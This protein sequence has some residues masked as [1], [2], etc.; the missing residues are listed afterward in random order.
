MKRFAMLS[1]GILISYGIYENLQ[2]FREPS[3]EVWAERSWFAIGGAMC[4][5]LIVWL[6]A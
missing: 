6:D 4:A 5:L 1:L 3:I 2:W